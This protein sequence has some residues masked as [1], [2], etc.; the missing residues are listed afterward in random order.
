ML[1]SWP[2]LPIAIEDYYMEI[3]GEGLDNIF[4]ALEHPDRVRSIKFRKY[5]SSV[6]EK[7]AE[8]MQVPFPE[9]TH[10]VLSPDHGSTSV[11]PDSFL[12]G[13]VPR[14]QTLTLSGI[15]F[16]AVPNLFL[17]ASDLVT[18]SFTCLPYYSSQS[19]VVCLSSL[20][21]LQSLSL[22]FETHWSRFQSSQS[23]PDQPDP[24]PWARVVLPALTNLTFEGSTDYSEDFLPRIDTPLL[25]KFSMSFFKLWGSISDALDIP[26]FKQFIG[27]ANDLKPPKVARVRFIP[28]SPLE[29]RQQGE[30][31][32]ARCY[33]I[34]WQVDSIALVCDQLSPFCSPIERFDLYAIRLP[35]EVEEE[36]MM[37]TQL[38][39]LFR[40]F[41][42]IQSLRVSECIVPLVATA[43]LD[44]I[45][46]RT[47]E[48]LPNL[49]DL[50]LG[51]SAIPETVPEAMQPF[52]TARQLSGQPVA[53]H[54][55]GSEP[56]E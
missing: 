6:W 1:D 52:V 54:H 38:G 50:F 19:M 49:R 9:L 36:D 7:L 48:A 11:L 43:L 39:E 2:A 33:R 40:R 3:W 24:S 45:G 47:T 34:D 16:P 12:G 22:G 56:S 30:L 23:R 13:S 15:P 4:A 25:N 14:L 5:S 44:V 35:F 55:W 10:L 27:R 37:Y 31:L 28:G 46:E 17:S 18:L 20:N 32:E 51:G 53:V 8:A 21:R 41:T 42:A 26:H 29:L